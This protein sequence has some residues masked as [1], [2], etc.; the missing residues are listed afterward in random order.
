MTRINVKAVL[1]ASVSMFFLDLVSGVLLLPIFSEIHVF[2]GSSA[3]QI[4]RALTA[5]TLSSGFLISTLISGTITTILGGYLAARIAKKYPYFNAAAFGV[6]GIAVSFI[7]SNNAP[8]WF[9][10]IGYLST[11]P[12]ALYGGHLAKQTTSAKT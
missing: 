10:V 9:D 1:I 2:D 6:I 7:L 3:E 8:L 5:V 11:L 4:D 12:A